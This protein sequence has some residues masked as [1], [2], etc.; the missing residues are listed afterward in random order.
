MTDKEKTNWVNKQIEDTDYKWYVL[1]IVSWQ[2]SVV[3]KNLHETV[4]KSKLEWQVEEIF[5]PEITTVKMMKNWEKKV[6]VKK[7]HPG[8][9]YIKSMM[10]DKIWYILRNTPGVRLIIWSDIYPTPVSDK[11]MED[12]IKTVKDSSTRAEMDVPYMIWD[13]VK[14]KADE[15]GGIEWEIIKI[16]KDSWELQVKTSLMW[17]ETIVNVTYN[18]VEKII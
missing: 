7:L 13:K 10:N 8:Y 9:V 16:N 11:E 5:F 12:V 3:V 17:R 6:T 18:K 2:E 14:L 15:L 1:S 4:K